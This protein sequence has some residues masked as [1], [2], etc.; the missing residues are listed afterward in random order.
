NPEAGGPS[1][2]DNE[3][4]ALL[5]FADLHLDTRNWTRARDF[6]QRA[7]VE[8]EARGDEAARAHA[9][10]DLGMADIGLNH[11]ALGK[12]EAAA[13]L[14]Q[15]EARGRDA[16]L[17]IQVNR[18]ASLLEQV[19]ETQE[20]LLRLR[21]SLLLENE[22][23]RSDREDTVV[24]LQRQ[25]SYEQH[26]R[27]LEQ[28]VHDNAMQSVEIARRTNERTLVALLALALGI[29]G[30][31]AGHL[32]LRA[33]R[34]NR[35]L[36]VNN[37][38]LAFA[39]L[40]DKVTGLLNR[41]AME[42]DTQALE[43]AGNQ[44]FCH[45][46]ISVKQFALIVGSLG[47]QLGDTLVCQIAAR[48]EAVAAGFDGKLYRIDG[49]TFGAIFTFGRDAGR[50]RTV[51]EGLTAAM[52][53][54]FPIGN[55]DIIVSVGA[56]ASEY[57]KDAGT[58]Q[59]V[60]RLAEL[61][62][63]QASGDPGNSFVVYDTRIGETQRDKLRMESRMLK[64]LE[65]GGFELFYQGQR[66][67]SDGRICG[68]EALLRWRDGDTM[69]SPAQFIPLAEETGLIVRIGSWVL[70]QAC[71]QARAWADSGAGR[72][73]VAVNIS[74]RQFNHP[75]FLATV[76][77]TLQRTGVDPAQ[78]EL[79][80][81]EGSV[82]DDAEA[83]IAQLHALRALGLHLAIDDFGTGYASLSYLRRFPLD[84]LKIDR[85]FI[86]QLNASEQDDTIVRT[87]IELAHTLGLSV[88]AEGVE[89]IEQE[90][91]L[92]QWGCDVIQ[93]FLRFRPAPATTATSQLEQDR[94]AAEA[95][96]S[97]EP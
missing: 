90:N 37:A 36:A 21:Q 88:T 50:L 16:E 64:A 60:A 68:F 8:A 94:L 20:S 30:G 39:S 14:A 28:L 24:A 18:Y 74:P 62:K 73:L 12:Q 42:A 25:S 47:H 61:A 95:E 70:E 86:K 78:I 17:L 56:G 43:L 45:V 81:T 65:H 13:G 85:S 67:M 46:T 79:E 1:W 66:G 58:A 26:Q 32:Y 40:H 10:I 75:D 71:R 2:L 69:I 55:Q 4:D 3:L 77:D 5:A 89:T 35:Q 96:A 59:E 6:A 15:M 83:S 93:G 92:G 23:T 38:E 84:R 72:P 97:A 44:A 22:L 80:I 54:P 41:R 57:P 9:R 87:V 53:A 63:L 7:V 34:S 48:L 49:V 33:R 29:G 31:V 51:L 27:H 52:D 19:G 11:R 82:M 76:R 91:Q